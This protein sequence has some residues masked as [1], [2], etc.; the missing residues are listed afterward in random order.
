MIPKVGDR[1][2][3]QT[4]GGRGLDDLNLLA[5]HCLVERVSGKGLNL[6]KVNI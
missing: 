2:R 4:G 1:G 6:F 3:P 5:C